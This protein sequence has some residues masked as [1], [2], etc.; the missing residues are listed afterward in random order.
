MNH[1]N[2]EKLA[3]KI[4]KIKNK[5]HLIEIVKIIKKDVNAGNIV[6][7]NNGLFMMFHNLSD[8]TYSK[9]EKFFKKHTKISDTTSE[10]YSTELPPDINNNDNYIYENQS[11]LK[12]SNKEK[13]IIKR[14][15]YDEILCDL[16]TN[17]NT[18]IS[19]NDNNLLE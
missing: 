14:K 5:Q 1:E 19:P 8:D 3:R 16:E 11:K 4:N 12:Y 2:K 15:L 7:N 13:C 9:I 6:E 17:N 10:K 18:N